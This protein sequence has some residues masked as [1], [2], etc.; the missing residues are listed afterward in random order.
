MKE[1]WIASYVYAYA[2]LKL[3]NCYLDED[4]AKQGF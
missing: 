1:V 2:R 3:F 4:L